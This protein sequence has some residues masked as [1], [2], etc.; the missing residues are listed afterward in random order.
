MRVPFV[1]EVEEEKVGPKQNVSHKKIYMTTPCMLPPWHTIK[2]LAVESSGFWP[3]QLH[4][5]P[6]KIDFAA[7]DAAL[8]SSSQGEKVIRNRVVFVKQRMVLL[9][10]SVTCACLQRPPPLS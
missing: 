1:V 6:E 10:L 4:I 3:L 5:S 8:F 7:D 9:S 2:T